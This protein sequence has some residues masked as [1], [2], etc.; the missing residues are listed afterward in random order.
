MLS[1][2]NEFFTALFLP[3]WCTTFS[4]MVTFISEHH[5]HHDVVVNGLCQMLHNSNGSNGSNSA[6]SQLMFRGTTMIDVHFRCNFIT[7]NFFFVVQDTLIDLLFNT[8]WGLRVESKDTQFTHSQQFCPHILHSQSWQKLS[9][10]RCV[11][12]DAVVNTFGLPTKIPQLKFVAL[13]N[14]CV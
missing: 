12:Y 7:A 1:Q 11:T 9:A 13:S 8:C 10:I 5:L 6:K 2:E 3:Q 14:T 4:S